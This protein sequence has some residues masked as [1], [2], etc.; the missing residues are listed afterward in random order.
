MEVV[1]STLNR[2]QV[3]KKLFKPVPR[4]PFAEAETALGA[5]TIWEV[6]LDMPEQGKWL[7][8]AKNAIRDDSQNGTKIYVQDALLRLPK[9]TN[10]LG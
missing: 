3:C 2:F 7:S 4:R 9:Q 8:K 10:P 1:D 5:S 6:R